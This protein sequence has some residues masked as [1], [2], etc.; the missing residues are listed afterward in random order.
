MNA[1]C[2]HG[3]RMGYIQFD[4]GYII[5]GFFEINK[6]NELDEYKIV[7]NHIKFKAMWFYIK[8]WIF[9]KFKRCK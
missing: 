7:A 4:N 1:C 5:R 3:N 9:N 8:R 2:G 6:K